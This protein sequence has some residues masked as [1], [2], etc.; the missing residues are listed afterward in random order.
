MNKPAPLKKQ[1]RIFTLFAL[2]VVAYLGCEKPEETGNQFQQAGTLKV[3]DLPPLELDSL[4]SNHLTALLEDREGQIWCGTDGGGISVF[5]PSAKQWTN[6][7]AQENG[8]ANNRVAA[9]LEDREGRI[10]C[11]T[12]GLGVSVFDPSTEKWTNYRTQEYELADDVV[13]ALLEDREGRIWCGTNGYGVSVFD[14]STQ[15]W[16]NYRAQVNGLA[17][18]YVLALL[19]D[20]EGRIW[21]GTALGGVS[22]FDPS[23]ENWTNYR[24]Q[25]N[26]LA[27]DDVQALLEDREGRIWCGTFGG[28][29]SVIDTSTQQWTNYRAQENG[30]ANDDV[31]ALL[32]DREG[33]IWCG[34]RSSGA[35]VFDP[36]KEKWTN[37]PAQQNGLAD[38]DVR[39]L[40]EDREGR[41]WCVPEGRGISVF[42]P[43]KEKWTNYLAQQ[44]GLADDAVRALLEDREGRIWCGTYGYGVS[45][46]DPS[47]QQWTNYRDQESGLTGD[48]VE[49]LLEDREGRIWCGTYGGGVG[50]F[51]PSKQN[52]TNYRSDETGLAINYVLGLLEDREGR[53]WCVPEGRGVRVFDPSKENWTNFLEKEIGIPDFVLALLEDREGRIWC[54]TDGLGVSVFDPNTEKWTNYRA[55]KN[56]LADDD[57]RALLED[58]EGRIWCG[59]YGGGVSVFDPGTKQWT[60]YREQDNG[61][62]DFVLALLE[63]REGRIWC[64]A[65]G[66][67]VSV[68]DPSTEKWTNYRAQESGLASYVVALLEDREGRI[69][70]GTDGSGVSVFQ[71]TDGSYKINRNYRRSTHQ[72]AVRQTENGYLRIVSDQFVIDSRDQSFEEIDR[73]PNNQVFEVGLDQQLWVGTSSGTLKRMAGETYQRLDNNSQVV[74]IAPSRNNP[75]LAWYSTTDG[76]FQTKVVDGVLSKT[77][78]NHVDLPEF[79]ADALECDDRDGVFIAYNKLPPPND[80]FRPEPSLWWMQND[81]KTVIQLKCKESDLETFKK[82]KIKNMAYD[83]MRGLWIATSAGLF[84][85]PNYANEFKPNNTNEFYLFT[86]KGRLPSRALKKVV[87]APNDPAG[88]VYTSLVKTG[89]EELQITGFRPDDL[90]Q[91]TWNES[92]GIPPGDEIYDFDVSDERELILVSSRYA[93]GPAFIAPPVLE[94]ART[95]TSWIYWLAGTLT[96]LGL[97]LAW[98]RPIPLWVQVSANPKQILELNPKAVYQVIQVLKHKKRLDGVWKLLGLPKSR[99]GTVE[100]IMSGEEHSLEG[101][102]ELLGEVSKDKTSHSYFEFLKAQ[103]AFAAIGKKEVCLVRFKESAQSAEPSKIREALQQMLKDQKQP[104]ELPFLV[105]DPDKNMAREWVP[106]NRSCI[107]G[108]AGQ[109]KL[110]SFATEPNHA[111]FGIM[112]TKG[113]LT[114]NHSSYVISGEVKNEEMFFGRTQEV[115]DLVNSG[116]AGMILVGPRRVGKTSILYAARK[117][118][119]EEKPEV[120]V[121][122]LSLLRVHESAEAARRLKRELRRNLDI[123][124]EST[125]DFRIAIRQWIDKSEAANRLLIIDE[126]D[127]LIETDANNPDE[128]KRY[129]MIAEL[130]DLQQMGQCAFVL[131]GYLYLFSETRN[132]NSPLYNFATVKEL[133]PLALDDATSLAIDPMERFGIRYALDKS[134]GSSLGRR[135]AIECGGYPSFVQKLC[136]SILEQVRLRATSAA[137]STSI[138]GSPETIERY[139]TIDE[140]LLQAAIASQTMWDYLRDVFEQNTTE[141]ARR[142]CTIMVERDSFTVDDVEKKLAEIG[143]EDIKMTT[144][145]LRL[146]GFLKMDRDQFSWSI[147]L[148]R[149]VIRGKNDNEF[150]NS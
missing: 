100:K 144:R 5:D 12:Y 81:G 28:G 72:H 90:E 21:C 6:Y 52:W 45:V 50:V 27:K 75:E 115:R 76:I 35:S 129:Q 82:S 7:R 38:D 117:Q 47:T 53:I 11:G 112:L 24:A 80:S 18:E 58:R 77:E 34:T 124:I 42:D 30:L 138:Y 120:E 15:Q 63:D 59:T 43:S 69:W 41:I 95:Q 118:L 56:G 20:R 126:A 17:D 46:F 85:K 116:N 103:I 51:D 40:L 128:N 110:L 107:R 8:L 74:S 57:V 26:G 32:E 60:N 36:S 114:E 33:R 134:N 105:Y 99:I 2:F 119:A 102:A 86:A 67:G 122:F 68:F 93:S 88:T 49:A 1:W 89:D 147:P 66:F 96:L 22:V 132:Q 54:G 19:E 123:E 48:I 136:I 94:N 127:L 44:N 150:G 62:P 87:V 9:L 70:C 104:Q 3:L 97:V 133:G 10:W 143:D 98:N 23:K 149:D 39:A 145:Q 61:I 83:P 137:N 131:C 148:L 13:R 140:K 55:Q 29:V 31:R 146:S 78:L 135:V 64:G 92:S 113:L 91:Y 106:K 25:E 4:P 71:R 141:A 14:P 16:T 37:Y 73:D 111:L 121:I 101:L 84:F 108:S 142:L 139:L 65:D 125:D 79:H 130:R 109:L